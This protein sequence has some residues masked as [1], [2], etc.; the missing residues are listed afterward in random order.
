[1]QLILNDYGCALI[2]DCDFTVVVA[3]AI[4]LA[5]KAFMLW[6]RYQN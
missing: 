3:A 4:A 5:D 1:M 2:Y 6:M